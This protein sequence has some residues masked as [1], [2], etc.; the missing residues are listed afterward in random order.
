MK[1]VAVCAYTVGI[2]HT[3]MAQKAI[4]NEF[5]K[6]GID[7]KVETQG[8]T[9][10]DNALSQE[11]IDAADFVLFSVDVG[12]EGDERFEEKRC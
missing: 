11:E 4:E 1:V 6:R 9:G 10:I 3:Y 12:V 5:K 2:A 8:G 7:I